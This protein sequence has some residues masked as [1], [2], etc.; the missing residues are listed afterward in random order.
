MI[1][2]AVVGAVGAVVLLLSML[3]DGFLEGLHLLDG[4]DA[5]D[6]AFSSTAIGAA[7]TLFGAGGVAALSVG[8][9]LWLAVV[10]P[11][12]IGL[13]AWVGI[14]RLTRVLKRGSRPTPMLASGAQGRAVTGITTAGE[15]LIDGEYNKR[16]AR[17][18]GPA[19]P[20]GAR[21]RVIDRDEPYLVVIAEESASD[22]PTS[23]PQ[24][25]ILKEN[26]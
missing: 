9:P 11:L 5:L 24:A 20:A 13:V 23:W 21:V 1:V 4:L 16:L 10:V 6:G 2:F 14:A 17:T 8:W 25:T 3:L 12:V 7:L 15:V 19:I 18:D 26:Q 22:D